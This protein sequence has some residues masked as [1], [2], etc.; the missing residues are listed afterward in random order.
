MSIGPSPISSIPAP[1]ELNGSAPFVPIAGRFPGALPHRWTV[2]QVMEAIGTGFLPEDSTV[3][4]IRGE[5]IRKMPVGKSH[6]AVVKRLNRWFSRVLGERCLIGVQDMI[7]LADSLPHPDFT[8]LV[9]LKDCYESRVVQP[10]DILLLIE[11]AD[12][13]LAFD[14]KIKL[15]I[16]AENGMLDYWIVNLIDQRIEVY[17]QPQAGGTYAETQHFGRGQSIAP[18]ALPDVLVPVDEILGS[19]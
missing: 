17:R 7:E 14:Q 15:P 11:V 19:G 5:L 3:E 10:P 4:L 18:L 2:A 12:S 16:Y 13:S 9:P 8:L 1:L 6:M